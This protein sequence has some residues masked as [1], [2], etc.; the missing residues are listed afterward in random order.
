MMWT[1]DNQKLHVPIVMPVVIFG[2]VVVLVT[3][4]YDKSN[5]SEVI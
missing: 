4:I 3:A 1:V 2:C 5:Q